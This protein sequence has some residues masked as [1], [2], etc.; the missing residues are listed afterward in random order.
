VVERRLDRLPCFSLTGGLTVFMAATA[1]SR[2]LGLALLDDLPADRALLIPRCRSVHTFGM[3]FA[4]D[5]VFIGRTGNAVRVVTGAGRRRA[6]GARDAQAVLEI[7]A[8]QAHRFIAAGA[9][10]LGAGRD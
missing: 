10:G 2:L 9:A 8:G 1:L 6:F 3:R 5:L 7:R 4:V